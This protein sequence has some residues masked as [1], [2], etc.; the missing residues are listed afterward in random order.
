MEES[1]NRKSKE[2]KE[3]KNIGKKRRR[4]EDNPT[5]EST[6]AEKY[7]DKSFINEEN[8]DN[9]IICVKSSFN[10][11]KSDLINIF[12]LYGKIIYLYKK[13]KRN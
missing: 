2:Q 11:R 8:I 10:L 13:Y 5:V 7:S 3:D 4:Q 9:K 6:N 1:V 12:K